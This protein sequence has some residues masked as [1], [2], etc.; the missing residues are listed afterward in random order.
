V[1]GATFSSGTFT[2][3]S[4]NISCSG[5]LVISGCAF[6][7][8]S[9][10]LS[11]SGSY[12]LSSGSFTHNNGR[13]TFNSTATLSGSTSFYRLDLNA[14]ATGKTFTVASGT[15]F[16]VTNDFYY[17]GNATIRVNTG[18]IDVKKNIYLQNTASTNLAGDATI[19]ISG[20]G[21]QTLNGVT[22]T[23]SV[24]PNVRIEKPGLSDTLLLVNRIYVRGNWTW[25]SGTVDAGTSLVYFY[26]A[27]S[28]TITGTH[29]LYDVMFFASSTNMTTNIAAGTTL[30]VKHSLAFTGGANGIG[31]NGGTINAQGDISLAGTSSTNIG[32][33]STLIRINGT[34]TQTLTGSLTPGAGRLPGIEIAK[35]MGTLYITDNI[36]VLGNWTWTSGTI[37][38]T[39]SIVY[40]TGT[41][42][43]TGSHALN[44]VIF[45]NGSN[46]TYTFATGTTLTVKNSMLIASSTNT[47]T[48]NGGTISIEGNLVITNSSTATGGTTSIVFTGAADQTLTGN[49]SAGTGK[50]PQVSIQKSGG[51]LYIANTVSCPGSWTYTSGTVLSNYTSGGVNYTSTVAFT[52]TS[53][54]DGQGTSSTMPFYNV[55]FSGASTLTGNLDVNNALSITGTLAAGSNTVNVGGS[56]SN[57]GTWTYATS[58]VVFDGNTVSTISKASGTETF[59]NLSVNRTENPARALSYLKAASPVQIN[60]SLTLTKGRVITD[61]TN[62]LELIDN[63]TCTTAAQGA[64][65]HGPVRKVGNDA[66]VFP[67]GDT[68]LVD[69]VAYHPL[70]ITAPGSTGDKF[71]ARYYAVGQTVGDSLVDSL[72]TVSD[73][74]YWSITRL[75]GS[76]NVTVTVGWNRNSANVDN[77]DDM[78]LAGWNGIKWLDL[79]NAVITAGSGKGN[80]TAS[81]STNFAANASWAVTIGSRV[82]SRGYAILKRK[83]D[84]GYYQCSNG[85]LMFRFDEEYND[86]DAKLSFRIYDDEHDEVGSSSDVIAGHEPLVYYGSNY[87]LL[88]VMSCDILP[89]G[90][91]INGYY[92]LEVINDKS[93]HWYLRFKHTTTISVICNGQGNPN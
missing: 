2:G 18:T 27:N 4:S 36:S 29:T 77:Y 17:L 87:Y 66:F 89:E 14:N 11:V 57:T 35:S 1:G 50:I 42:T 73:Q 32:G 63:A 3:G 34:G 56:W 16:T 31:L 41:K 33:G 12:T 52:G 71:M 20:S 37:D 15:T 24:L 62:Y 47:V 72:A 82:N 93:E 55:L 70:G 90:V 25:I 61:A 68:A 59:Y 6:T 40:F 79:G 9:A 67:L 85:K 86:P 7:S 49:G 69:S 51:T 44:A 65:V 45:N 46:A 8:T 13:V 78:R 84:A 22:A 10:Q 83:L 53:N 54:V 26:D 75:A 74:E 5:A 81:I 19:K 91:L 92:I 38:A 48:L 60:A 64:Y 21:K 58:T 80:I 88:N 28:S 39:S 76:S 23:E 43:I 30:T